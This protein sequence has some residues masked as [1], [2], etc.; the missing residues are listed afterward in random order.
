MYQEI[1]SFP[2]L[3]Y[4]DTS[5]VI[6][7]GEGALNYYITMFTEPHLNKSKPIA[8][9][10]GDFQFSRFSIYRHYVWFS[11]GEGALNYITNPH[12]FLIF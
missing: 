2:G 1:S 8:D 11:L 5:S 6:L 9:V 12:S 4:I 3:V 10:P 7:L